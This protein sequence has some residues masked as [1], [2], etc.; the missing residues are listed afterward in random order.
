AVAT[1]RAFHD[2]MRELW[3][4]HVTWTR[5][6]IV[7]FVAELPDLQATT[8][9]LL[10]NQVDIGDAVKPFYGRAAGDQLTALLRDHIL[11]AADLLGAAKG[12]DADAFEQA[13]DAW[14]A[15]ARQIARFLHDANP[16]NWALA[17]LR[18]MMRDHLDLT[19]QEAAHQLG[20]DY[21]AS[22]ADYDA[23]VT[24]ILE[25]ADMLSTGIIKQFPNAFA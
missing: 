21:A 7:S 4:D 17:D 6:F 11:T 9:R 10:Q 5:L 19:L 3:E 22:V 20:G 24:E 18:T 15:N 25:M 14:Y 23:V 1:K 8:D 12:G 13:H 16:D 2:G